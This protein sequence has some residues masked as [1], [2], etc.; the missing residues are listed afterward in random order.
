M[1]WTNKI[2]LQVSNL[3]KERETILARTQTDGGY[4]QQKSRTLQRENAQLH[5]K[6]KGQ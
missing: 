2:L 5:L 3:R 1:E 6:V 4:D